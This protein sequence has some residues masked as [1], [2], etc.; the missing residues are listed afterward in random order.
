MAETSTH[1]SKF[2]RKRANRSD[3]A[4][5]LPGEQGVSVGYGAER[6]N[7]SARPSDCAVEKELLV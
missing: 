2:F 1:S 7:C 5:Q 4:I 3:D 6:C